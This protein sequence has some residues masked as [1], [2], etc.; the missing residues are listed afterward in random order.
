MMGQ[1]FEQLLAE[2]NSDTEEVVDKRSEKGAFYTPRNII[3]E[4]CTKSLVANF[5]SNFDDKNIIREFNMLTM[6]PEIE[7]LKISDDFFISEENKEKIFNFY[8]PD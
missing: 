1:I 6:T 2:I 5:E 8:Q 4:I 3:D 7:F